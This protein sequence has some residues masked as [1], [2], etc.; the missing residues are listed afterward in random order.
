[1]APQVGPVRHLP[2]DL[3]PLPPTPTQPPL[4]FEP[5]SQPQISFED[6]PLFP[7]PARPVPPPALSLPNQLA[8]SLPAASTVDAIIQ[9]LGHS[10]T[11]SQFTF[12]PLPQSTQT[13]QPQQQYS[14][15]ALSQSLQQQQYLKHYYRSRVLGKHYQAQQPNLSPLFPGTAPEPHFDTGRGL[16]NLYL[17]TMKEEELADWLQ[18]TGGGDGS[19]FSSPNFA[20]IHDPSVNLNT[21]SPQDIF[22]Y[23]VS[24]PMSASL[25]SP[26][27]DDDTSYETSPLFTND[28]SAASDNHWP[29]LFPDESPYEPNMD[30]EIE[31]I[32]NTASDEQPKPEPS[33]SPS[34]SPHNRT[35]GSVRKASL[36]GA[37]IRK[38]TVPLPPIVVEDPNDHV[39]VKRA[40]NTLAA[41]KSREKKV[42]KMEEMEIQIEELKAQVE[43]WKRLYMLKT[44]RIST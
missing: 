29:S 42:R 27:L 9:S 15:R 43:H 31:A 40:R 4:P 19:E 11:S 36:T 14:A 13:Q 3:P 23:P 28:D 24:T 30:A 41:R 21:V 35:S 10:T 44:G 32:I 7:P 34:G 39:A 17:E 26:Y 1:M 38:R 5:S 33:I 8:H 25:I 22:S 20:H 2:N 6:P 37:G 16:L 12:R 18:V